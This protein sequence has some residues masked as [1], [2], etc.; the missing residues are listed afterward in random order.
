MSLKHTA[1]FENQFIFNGKRTMNKHRN[2]TSRPKKEIAA[3]YTSKS[4]CY[5]WVLLENNYCVTDL[6]FASK[7]DSSGNKLI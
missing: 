3:G 7:C 1:S 5:F 4:A 2:N 6:R